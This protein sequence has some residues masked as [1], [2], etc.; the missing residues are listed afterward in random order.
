M[1]MVIVLGVVLLSSS[2]T[3]NFMIRQMQNKIHTMQMNSQV[4]V[5]TVSGLVIGF[6]QMDDNLVFMVGTGSK[7][8]K[9]TKNSQITLIKD[10]QN[11][12]ETYW[13]RLNSSRFSYTPE[14][15]KLINVIGKAK[16]AY[17]AMEK[18]IVQADPSNYSMAYKSEFLSN[19]MANAFSQVTSSAQKIKDLAIAVNRADMGDIVNYANVA[20]LISWIL[21]ALAVIVGILITWYLRKSLRPLQIVNQAL[22][23]MQNGDFKIKD[24]QVTARDEIGEIAASLNAMKNS[25]SHTLHTVLE[26]AM[27]VA[28]TSE[29]LM[30]SSEGVTFATQ[31]VAVEIEQVAQKTDLQS[32]N[33]T[34]TSRAVNEMTE[35]IREISM[36]SKD[37]Q[38]SAQMTRDI[39]D[40]GKHLIDSAVTQMEDIHQTVNG[41]SKSVEDLHG[42][43]NQIANIVSVIT[44]IATQTNLLAL[45]AAIE[46]ARAGE[47]GRGF[48]VVAELVRQLAEQSAVNAQQIVQIVTSIKKEMAIAMERTRTVTT[49]VSVGVVTAQDAGK[50]FG[51]IQTAI[52]EMGNH[53]EEIASFS[54]QL[55]GVALEISTS[56]QSVSTIATDNAFSAHQVTQA[57]KEQLTTMDEITASSASLAKLAENLNM[58]IGQFS[59]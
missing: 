11:Q 21:I 41:L 18:Q 23:T 25:M 8:D 14:E 29:Q 49:S 33:T 15:K 1:L 54:Q 31:R 2:L 50:S 53:T 35:D 20:D 45:N 26:E 6:Y 55:A 52:S 13:N 38:S 32:K 46:A 42:L 24:L 28:A 16:K 37:I 44:E 30:A 39:S 7:I 58:T 48:A 56:I 22:Q 5:N 10:G 12:F 19:G 4:L 34:E 36:L 43:S 27:N 51:E 40:K 9:A 47:Q 59:V 17:M 57:T 3:S